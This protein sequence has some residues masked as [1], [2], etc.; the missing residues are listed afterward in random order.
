MRTQT[1][2]LLPWSRGNSIKARSCWVKNSCKSRWIVA[3]RRAW[4]SESVKANSAKS[5]GDRWA[6]RASRTSKATGIF[7][8]T[9]NESVE[10]VIGKLPQLGEESSHLGT[11]FGFGIAGLGLR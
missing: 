7:Q 10:V 3:W 5:L 1:C 6:R 8:E 9:A 4:P 2:T 11:G